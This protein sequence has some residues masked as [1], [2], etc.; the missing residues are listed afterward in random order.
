MS[1]DKKA[2]LQIDLVEKVT[3]QI[4]TLCSAIILVLVTILGYYFE[5]FASR[6]IPLI[7]MWTII[8]ASVFFLASII[9][10]FFVY[11][12]LIGSLH[13]NKKLEDMSV[14]DNP[15]RC[16]A[17]LQW[18]TFIVGITLLIASLYQISFMPPP[19]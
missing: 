7:C 8:F 6:S 3:S 12:S 2:E 9:L 16:C 17:I 14:Y 13:C 19:S 1:S 10:G 15:L 11:G 5:Y 18:I 4:I